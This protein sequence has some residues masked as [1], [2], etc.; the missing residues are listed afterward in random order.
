[1]RNGVIGIVIGLVVGVVVGATLI[2]PRL[3]PVI[4]HGIPIAAEGET[5]AGADTTVTS[6]IPPAPPPMRW[7]MASAYAG[8]LPHL[9]TLGKRLD[10]EIW[11]ISGGDME[12]KFHEPD[13]LVPAAEMFD[14]VASGAIETAF[15]SPG[16]WAEKAPA[17]QLFAAVPFGPS[18]PEYLAWVYFGGGRELFEEIYHRHNLHGVF[19]GIVAPEASGWFREEIRT[20]ED[21]KGLR[22]RFFGLGAK[23]MAKL[24]VE[25]QALDGGDIF[26]ALESGAIDAAEY[27]MPAIDLKLGIHRMA[28]HYY[29]PGWHQ[30]ATL[31][32]LIVN[33][34]EWKALSAARKARIEV[35]CGDN[36]RHGLAEGEALQFSA[37]KDLSAAGVKIHRWPSKILDALETAWQEVA[38]EEVAADRDFKRVW[39]SLSAF[40]EDYAVWRELGYP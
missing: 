5:L 20:A 24:G 9:G 13:T 4:P 39:E 11:Q 2:A 3:A 31:F 38:N 33:L 18:A 23:V 35:A 30:P 34:D 19:C 22:M 36:V 12:M 26:M 8:S 40:R 25:P 32:D 27:S 14:A 21:L 16:A 7:R 37:L 6:P 15:S 1:M 29:F 10:R 17:L 28:K